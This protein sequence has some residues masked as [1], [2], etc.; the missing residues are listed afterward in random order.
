MPAV[1]PEPVSS[2]SLRM[3][4]HSHCLKKEDDRIMIMIDERLQCLLKKATDLHASDLHLTVGI[5]PAV[6]VSGELIVLEEERPLRPEDTQEMMFSVVSEDNLMQFRRDGE[7]DFSFGLPQ[8]GRFRVNMYRQRGSVAAAIRIMGG[9]I[10][11][12]EELGLPQAV[13]DL[14]Q[15]P[16]GLVLV[17]GP[18]GSGKST[19]LASLIQRINETRRCHVLTLEDPIEYLYRHDRALVDQREIGLDSM[20]F[21]AALRAALREDPDVILVGEMRDNE[22]IST[23]LTAAETGHLVFSTLHTNDAASTIGRIIDVFPDTQKAQVRTQLSMVLDAVISQRLLPR[24]DTEG[25]IACFEVMLCNTAVRSLIR[26]NKAFQIHN[27]IQTGGKSGMITMEDSM[28][29]AVRA[30]VISAQTALEFAADPQVMK[31]RLASLH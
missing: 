24:E 29:Q 25:R 27:V 2:L 30:G 4:A 9:R 15:R 3:A 13:I 21:A 22:T 8:I 19:T 18:T 7:V 14:V 28:L 20:S 12:P 16:S 10:P 26:D 31:G 5:P 11:A 1:S 23:A 6:R 17:A